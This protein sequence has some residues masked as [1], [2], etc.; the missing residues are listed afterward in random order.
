MGA[1]VGLQ[2]IKIGTVGQQLRTVGGEQH[3]SE[4]WSQGDISQRGSEEVNSGNCRI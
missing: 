4:I 3:T 2:G 1:E